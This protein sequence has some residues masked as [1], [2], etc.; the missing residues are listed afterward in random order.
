MNE[1]HEVRAR[2][3]QI[4]GDIFQTIADPTRRASLILL[5]FC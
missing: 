1:V 2:G 5:A 3:L 4:R